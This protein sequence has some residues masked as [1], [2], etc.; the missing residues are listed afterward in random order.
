MNEDRKKLLRLQARRRGHLKAALRKYAKVFNISWWFQGKGEDGLLHTEGDVPFDKANVDAE[1]PSSKIPKKLKDFE[2]CGTVCCIAG[3]DY[4]RSGRSRQEQVEFYG[5]SKDVFF[6]TRWP[7]SLA[8]EYHIYS[9]IS[10]HNGMVAAAE[11]AIDY[12]AVKE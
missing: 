7:N 8:D 4:L 5:F 11:K 6:V 2:E 9:R 3:L 12:F 10:D 1:F